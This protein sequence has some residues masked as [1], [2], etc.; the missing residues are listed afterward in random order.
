[1][2]IIRSCWK[3]LEDE[4]L[5]TPDHL[6]NFWM[7]LEAAGSVFIPMVIATYSFSSPGLYKP[8]VCQST[9]PRAGVSSCCGSDSLALCDWAGCPRSATNIFFILERPFLNSETLA[10]HYA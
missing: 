6:G 4:S 3:L 10:I 8:S 5:V 2:G 1:M 7:L 9:R